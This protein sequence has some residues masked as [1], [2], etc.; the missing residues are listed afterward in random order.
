MARVVM[1]DDGIA[2]DG[3]MAETSP[4]GGAETA[5]VALAEALAARG[6]SVEACTQC[7]EALTH[8]G[9]RWAPFG[10]G[11]SAAC[12]LYIGSRGHRVIGG[13]VQRAGRR[14]FWLHN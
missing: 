6:H 11:L 12:D 8:R 13:G 14:L 5:F 3:R 1:A 10:C 2:F 7:G 9:V 4:L